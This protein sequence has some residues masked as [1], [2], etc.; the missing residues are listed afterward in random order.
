[1]CAMHAIESPDAA[2]KR[3]SEVLAIVAVVLLLLYVADAVWE[4]LG[5]SR[6]Q[7]LSVNSRGIIFGGGALTMFIV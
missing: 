2:R 1:M 7:Q 6:F 5:N 4:F 3:M